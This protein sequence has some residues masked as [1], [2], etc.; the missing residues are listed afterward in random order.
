MTITTRA[1]HMGDMMNP[2]VSSAVTIASTDSFFFMVMDFDST[3]G[4]RCFL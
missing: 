1:C 2:I 4:S 3:K